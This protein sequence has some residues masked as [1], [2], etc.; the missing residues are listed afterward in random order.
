MALKPN[1]LR[2]WLSRLHLL[3]RLLGV[4]GLVAVATGAVLAQAQGMFGTEETTWGQA[5]TS[6]RDR[7]LAA[8]QGQASGDLLARV[9]VYLVLGGAAAALLWLLVEVVVIL[10]FAAARRSAFGANAVVQGGIAAALL[11]GINLYSYY[12]Y[13][14]VDCT[15]TGEFTLPSD[16]QKDFRQLRPETA[17]TILVLLQPA[18]AVSGDN[19]DYHQAAAAEKVVINKVRELADQLR[20]FGP[21]FRVV[22]LDTRDEDYPEKLGKATRPLPGLEDAIKKA[23]PGNNIF[24]YGP[25]DRW[26]KGERESNEGKKKGEKVAE[27][28]HIQRISFD[29]FYQL[30]RTRSKEANDGRGNL[31]LLNKGVHPLARRI[32]NLEEKRPRVGILVVDEVFSTKSDVRPEWRLDGLK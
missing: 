28:A 6:I 20:D 9:T 29:D 12:H 17:T 15:R 27:G 16:V 31:V 7:L 24:F 21:Q 10:R 18:K 5:L 2:V 4:T 3:V 14:R 1:R 22:V 13:R 26:V 32:L 30:D 23:P 25:P 11:V 8:V 19:R